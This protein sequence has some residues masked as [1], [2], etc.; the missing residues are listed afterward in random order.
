MKVT[1]E[2][3]TV[4]SFLGFS[5]NVSGQNSLVCRILI[6]IHRGAKLYSQRRA[7]LKILN[8][9]PGIFPKLIVGSGRKSALFRG[10]YMPKFELI[11]DFMSVL[12]AC[13]FEEDLIKNDGDIISHHN[14]HINSTGTFS[15]SQGRVTPK[16]IV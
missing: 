4:L 11:R 12:V 10:F 14:L 3:T 7:N 15:G 1:G 16:R 9:A 6:L 2:Q 13:M 8:S 5:W